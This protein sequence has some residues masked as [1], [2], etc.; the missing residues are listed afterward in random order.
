MI[1]ALPA[2]WRGV[3]GGDDGAA[4]PR[5]EAGE[6]LGGVEVDR[7]EVGQLGHEALL[8]RLFGDAHAL[9]DVGPGGA[10]AAGLVDEV[11]DEVI[12]EVAEGLG[13]QHGVGQLLEGVGVDRLIASMRSSRRT[14]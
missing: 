10:R 4:G 2:S 5:G 13:G 7:V 11:A 9:A 1:S 14:G 6:A 3:L 8:G 12:G